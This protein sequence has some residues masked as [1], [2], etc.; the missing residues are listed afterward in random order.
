M[1]NPGQRYAYIN[2]TILAPPSPVGERQF[3]VVLLNPKG[4]AGLGVGST[5]T[6]SIEASRLAS[7]VFQFADSSLIVTVEEITGTL[8]QFNVSGAAFI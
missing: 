2:I 4:G 3:D 6:I 7:G 1:L 5:I 8:A